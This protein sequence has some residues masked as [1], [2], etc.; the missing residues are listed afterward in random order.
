MKT[1]VVATIRPWNHAA[2]KRWKAPKGY[3]KVLITRKDELTK[4]KLEKI[5]PEYIFFP[6]WSS[7][8]P[9]DVYENFE[10]V[11][12][13]M[14]DL[15]FGRGGSPLQ[16][17]IVRGVRKTKLS[18][19]RVSDGIDTGPIYLKR[20]FSIDTGT[21][22]EIYMKASV[23]SFAMMHVIVR[24]AMKPKPQRG[25][26]VE[27]KRRTPEMS[28]LPPLS[29]AR[30]LYDFIRMLDAPEYP[31]AFL[32]DGEVRVEFRNVRLK[33]TTVTSDI[34]ITKKT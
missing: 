22:E 13:H 4:E 11:V 10:C 17:L 18:A 23:L 24:R 5:K 1:V 28:K 31:V 29:S 34:T 26:V 7:I 32:E 33:G 27:F 21:A 25:T 12:F 8:I 30:E 2:F 14:T 6:H 9:K 3:R 19:L 15:P 16:N 20:P